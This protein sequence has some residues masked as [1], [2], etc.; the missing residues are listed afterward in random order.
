MAN[1]R[2]V[3]GGGALP[4]GEWRRL[5]ELQTVVGLSYRKPNAIEF[6]DAAFRAHERGEPF[7]LIAEREPT[8]R[9]DRHAVKILGWGEGRSAILGRR[10]PVNVHVGYVD[11]D[12]SGHIA[13]KFPDVPLAAEFYSLYEGRNGYIDIC[14]FLSAPKSMPAA[15]VK[16]RRLLEAISDELIVLIYAAKSDDKLGRFEH[17]ILGKYAELRAQDLAM[18]LDSDEIAEMRR[19]CKAQEPGGE[20]TEAAIMRL[21]ERPQADPE[22]LWEMIEIVLT[23]DGKITKGEKAAA[24]ELAGYIEQTFGRNPLGS[25]RL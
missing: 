4:D 21:A 20:E 15:S 13:E 22:G 25:M 9:H 12:T 6:A 10:V 3:K 8:N 11:A 14:F 1:F 19:W 17:N 2:K 5:T 18:A 23:I 7:G 16:S 24:L